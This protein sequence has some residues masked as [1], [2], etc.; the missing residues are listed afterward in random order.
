MVN[1]EGISVNRYGAG[2]GTSKITE[3]SVGWVLKQCEREGI[4]VRFGNTK[5]AAKKVDKEKGRFGGRLQWLN[6]VLHPPINSHAIDETKDEKTKKDAQMRRREFEEQTL[7][8]DV[9]ESLGG[10]GCL[11][12]SSERPLKEVAPLHESGVV[13]LPLWLCAGFF[14]LCQRF[15]SAY[16]E[17]MDLADTKLYDTLVTWSLRVAKN[18][19]VDDYRNSW[20]STIS[21]IGKEETS[22]IE[23][24]RYQQ[25]LS[26]RTKQPGGHGHQPP[27]WRFPSSRARD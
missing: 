10:V 2:F 9:P 13:G 11:P 3:T 5:T 23:H 27:P 21:R 16:P 19:Y 14:G 1:V 7:D 6:L 18:K 22:M 4:F 8:L 24:N 25:D 26:I 17:L 12:E 15:E 20:P